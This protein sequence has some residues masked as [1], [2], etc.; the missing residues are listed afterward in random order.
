VKKYLKGFGRKIV[1]I[2]IIE[3]FFN[4]IEASKHILLRLI[5]VD[6]DYRIKHVI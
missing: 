5:D 2:F 3:A 6:P 4:E 1:A